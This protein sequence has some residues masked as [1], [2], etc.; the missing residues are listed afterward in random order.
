MHLLLAETIQL[1]PD[2]T[3]FIHIALI[4]IMIWV[5][6]RT[7]YRPINKV[8]EAREANKGG[9]SSEAASILSDAE[10][11]EQRYNR[12]LLE[13]RSAGYEMIEKEQKSATAAREK[14]M[15]EV[16]TEVAARL[17]TGRS[18]IEQETAAAR[19]TIG[20]DAEKLADKIAANILKA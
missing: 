7:L 5:L 2:G 13:A 12:E 16:K 6:N 9:H 10:T 17:E 19:A 14:L 20:T 11:K 3:L 1:F 18:A 4:L 8:L 15:N